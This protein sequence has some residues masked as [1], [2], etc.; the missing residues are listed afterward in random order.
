MR[1]KSFAIASE[2][3]RQVEQLARALRA[4]GAGADVV[5]EQDPALAIARCNEDPIAVFTTVKLLE[6]T[7]AAMAKDR[8]QVFVLNDEP[9]ETAFETALADDR[10][11][12]L[13]AWGEHG[14]R[15]WELRYIA[16]RL[17]APKEL[18]PH[19]G[20]LLGWGATTIH[21]APSTTRQQ[22]DIVVRIE[23]LGPRLGL[24]SAQSASLSVAA[25][26]LTMNAMYDA[27]VDRE[28]N[29]KYALERRQDLALLPNEVGS[30][31]FTVTGN[32]IALDMI[33]PFGRLPRG[34]FFEAVLRGHR[35]MKYGRLDLDTT[36]GGAGL[37][38]HT[39][40]NTGSILRAEVHPGRLTHVSW[41]LDRE[42]PKRGFRKLPR[43]LY[44]LTDTSSAV[45]W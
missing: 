3:G 12:G 15:L 33:D 43:S 38:L 25:H 26:E 29:V 16:R 36:H 14:G 5:V 20:A 42:A 18:P 11:G 27:P 24:T 7:L 19:L 10:I 22:R 8:W 9:D 17:L 41:V 37:G 44:Y 35:N 13:L 28:G 4:A 40:Y 1:G 32:F 6:E 31:R 21:W 45:R 23:T 39:L 30:L 2:K 34:R